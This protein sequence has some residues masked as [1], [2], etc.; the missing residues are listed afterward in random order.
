MF[1][2]FADQEESDHAFRRWVETIIAGGTPAAYGWMIEGTGVAFSNYGRGAPGTIEDQVMLGVDT[3]QG[4]IVKIVRPVTAQADRGKR[5]VIARGVGGRPLLLREG[6]LQRNALSGLIH[7][8][9]SELSGLAEVPVSVSGEPSHRHWYLVADLDAAPD[10]IMEQTASF[11]VACA[12]ARGAVGGSVPQ[13]EPK[14]PCG[15]GKDEKGRLVTVTHGGGTAEVLCLQGY[16][17]EQLQKVVGGRLKKPQHG[18]FCVD[19]VLETAGLLIEIKTGVFA[20]DMYAAVG[21]LTLYPALIRLPA[22]LERALVVPDA[23][24]MNPLIQSAIHGA[25]IKIYTYAVGHIGREPEIVFSEKLLERC[26][27][28]SDA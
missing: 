24:A 11:T 25:G 21:Q 20:H 14:T 9:F 12:R 28:K 1:E 23:P 2:L 10:T 18:G 16:V 19:G 6:R 26:R 27:Q 17:Y 15:Y 8:D 4:G 22:G 7:E 13:P 3:E 5:T